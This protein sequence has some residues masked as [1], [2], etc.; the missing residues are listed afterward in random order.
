V[1]VFVAPVGTVG[2]SVLVGVEVAPP[3]MVGVGVRVEPVGVGVLVTVG[4]PGVTVGPVGVG[5][6]VIF[7]VGLG[8][9]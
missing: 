7:V 4:P 1:G 9:P 8:A 5:V 3:R 6:L 2:V